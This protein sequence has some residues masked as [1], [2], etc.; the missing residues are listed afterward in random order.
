MMAA[1]VFM[2]NRGGH[3]LP[4]NM[5]LKETEMKAKRRALEG[6]QERKQTALLTIHEMRLQNRGTIQRIDSIKIQINNFSH[7]RGIQKRN[8]GIRKSCLEQFDEQL[9]TQQGV[10]SQAGLPG[11]FDSSDCYYCSK[12]YFTENY[13]KIK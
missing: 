6:E 13:G 12:S 3:P 10:L 1:N 8:V 11:F 7:T 4:P 9:A 2:G 5:E